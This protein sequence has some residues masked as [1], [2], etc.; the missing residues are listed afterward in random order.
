[1]A[2]RLDDHL[3]SHRG[4]L[5]G[6]EERGALGDAHDHAGTPRCRDGAVRRVGRVLQELYQEPPVVLA[7]EEPLGAGEGARRADVL[8]GTVC[9]TL[10]N[11]RL[12]VVAV[13]LH[14]GTS[15]VLACVVRHDPTL[16]AERL[17]AH[18]Q[19]L[20]NSRYRHPFYQ[21]TCHL[22]WAVRLCIISTL[23]EPK[24]V[25]VT[26]PRCRTRI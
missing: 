6:D 19:L 16:Q 7:T 5:V 17:H 21:V 25:G 14:A 20:P 10:G 4:A 3:S 15:I 22:L 18:R 1:M 26:S 23:R 13:A 24:T 11:L 2:E 9:G 8:L 12:Q